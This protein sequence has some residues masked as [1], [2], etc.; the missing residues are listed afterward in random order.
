MI[1]WNPRW[2]SEGDLGSHR[3]FVYD[4][5]ALATTRELK[6]GH[7]ISFSY[8]TIGEKKEIPRLAF[9][10]HPNHE[11]K[12]HALTL[13]FIDRNTLVEDIFPC[14]LT[15]I[16]NPNDFY[17]H[18]YKPSAL[19]QTDSYRTYFV[20]KMKSITQFK[21]VNPV[22]GS[23]AQKMDDYFN[24][25]D[26][27]RQAMYEYFKKGLGLREVKEYYTNVVLKREKKE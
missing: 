11:G 25:R 10:M 6:L 20:D 2:G 1:T 19:Y 17:Y 21:Y 15:G 23:D 9:V 24:Y 26:E 13:K 4:P 12:C 16:T 3:G 14:L 18:I 27:D 5:H 22:K 7:V 8:Q